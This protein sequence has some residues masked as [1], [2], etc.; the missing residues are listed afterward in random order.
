MTE[1]PSR[2]RSFL[3]LF[4]T[5]PLRELLYR[6]RTEGGSPPRLALSVALGAFIGC[7]PL[8]GAHFLLCF[9]AARIFRLNRLLTYAASH[10]SFPALLPL[11]LIAEVEVGR[12]LRG[13]P[14]ASLESLSW[15]N[16]DLK[17]TGLDLALGSPIVGLVLGGLLGLLT[18]WAARKRRAH[19]EETLLIEEAAKKYLD[20][21]LLHWEFVRGKLRYDPL[22]FH[23]LRRGILPASGSLV[24]LGCGRCILFALLEA[25]TDQAERGQYPPGWGPV[26]YLELHG[27]EGRPKTAAAARHAVG[28]RATIETADLTGATLPPGDAVLLLD[29]LHYLAADD[30]ERVLDRA[31]AALRPRG[32]LLLREADAG[33][34]W[35]FL[36]TRLQER[37]ASWLR[38]HFRQ[39]FRYRT[40]A[41]WRRMCEARG[42][43]TELHPLSHGTPY[44]NVLVIGR[45]EPGRET[46]A[47]SAAGS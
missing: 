17:T 27:I 12:W 38:G 44:G 14:P 47:G 10:I 7:L 16:L 20:T 43:R 2:W 6:L 23:L 39:R 34:G 46:D 4:S 40:I 21:G 15:R 8:Y 37:L 18:F 25:A 31:A 29:V 13:A 22:Y 3:A 42:L 30:Q 1:R 11:L 26:P 41:D 32:V 33:A 9:L 19:P 36:A 5:R 28:E 35:R 24:D 45:R